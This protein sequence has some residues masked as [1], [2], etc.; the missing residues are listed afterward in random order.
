MLGLTFCCLH[1]KILNKLDQQALNFHLSWA[2]Q[3]M[4]LVLTDAHASGTV[5]G[6][7]HVGEHASD[8]QTSW[9]LSSWRWGTAKH[10]TR[11]SGW[12]LPF[13]VETPKAQHSGGGFPGNSSLPGFLKQN[14]CR[15]FPK[16]TPHAPGVESLMSAKDQNTT[17]CLLWPF[18]PLMVHCRLLLQHGTLT[19]Q[20]PAPVGI[21]N[22]SRTV[23]LPPVCS[24][25]G[26]FLIFFFFCK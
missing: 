22:R 6:G 4:P 15:A 21:S 8:G 25:Q 26:F 1:L 10:L 14:L 19:A 11:A 5:F 2:L 12:E 23:A 7:Q 24:R 18:C 3:I 16:S 17:L 20:L 9:A 13:L